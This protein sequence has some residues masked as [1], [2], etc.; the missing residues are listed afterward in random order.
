MNFINRFTTKIKELVDKFKKLNQKQKLTILSFAMTVCLILLITL[1]I[2]ISGSKKEQTTTLVALDPAEQTTA[3]VIETT[4]QAQTTQTTETITTQA[5]TTETTTEKNFTTEA[6]TTTEQKTTEVKANVQE[7]IITPKTTTEKP[8]TTEETTTEKET[9]TEETTTEEKTTEKETTTEENSTETTTEATEELVEEELEV[10]IQ[11]VESKLSEIDM[12]NLPNEVIKSI[13]TRAEQERDVHKKN[14]AYSATAQTEED[15]LKSD[16]ENCEYPIYLYI[17]YPTGSS[18]DDVDERTTMVNQVI[19]LGKY[20]NIDYTY[21]NYNVHHIMDENGRVDKDKDFYVT[22]RVIDK[23]NMNDYSDIVKA[24]YDKPATDK[25]RK[26]IGFYFDR[27]KLDVLSD[28]EK[29]QFL[30][31]FYRLI[32]ALIQDDI[33]DD[34]SL[35]AIDEEHNCASFSENDEKLWWLVLREQGLGDKSN[36]EKKDIILEIEKDMLERGT[37]Q[38][39][40]YAEIGIC[41]AEGN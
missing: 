25:D 14:K 16:E 18:G 36:Y 26:L 35:G 38:R 21:K 39:L 7:I 41:I 12:S 6:T 24:V 19:V 37:D 3:Q 27:K 34:K 32:D 8:T 17:N 9:T 2:N 11:A 22:T 4:T 15:V 23:E 33:L 5:Q 28:I 1:V 30:K 13:K 31:D 10:D 20:K 29:A 40:N